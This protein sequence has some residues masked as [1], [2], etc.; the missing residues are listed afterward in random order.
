MREIWKDI[1][2]YEGYYQVS[3]LGRVR[4]LDREV[5]TSNGRTILRL[6]KLISLKPHSKRKYSEI[7]LYRS[8]KGKASKVHRLVAQ[9]FIPNPENK[10]VVNHL[11]GIKNNNRVENLEWCNQSRNAAH[12]FEIGLQIGMKGSKNHQSK[13][14]SEM[15]LNICDLL[16][17]SR[18]TQLDIASIY[19]VDK[20]TIQ[21]INTGSNWNW[22]TK[23]KD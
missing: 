14:T 12:S 5:R 23:R 11:N 10:P 7:N 8:G 3:N 1:T 19:G 17:T 6:G 21:K 2:D 16:D 9:A 4:S 13:L 22:L 15:V 18:K 20:T